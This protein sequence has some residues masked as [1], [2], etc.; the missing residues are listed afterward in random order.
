MSSPKII[1]LKNDFDE[2]PSN[3]TGIV[4]WTTVGSTCLYR[5]G[6]LHNEFGPAVIYENSPMT[7]L[8]FYWLDGKN[9]GEREFNIMQYKKYKGSELAGKFAAKILGEKDDRDNT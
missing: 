3:Y 8:K 1:Q 9:I 5:N 2:L 7:Q 6:K 4:Q